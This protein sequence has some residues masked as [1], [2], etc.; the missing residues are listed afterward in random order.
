MKKRLFLIIAISVILCCLFAFSVSAKCSKCTDGWTLI[1]GEDGYFGQIEALNL[2]PVCGTQ[3]AKKVFSPMFET[4]GYSHSDDGIMQ[5]YAVNRDTVAKFEELTG[6]TIKFGSVVATRNHVGLNPLDE[7]GNPI[8]QKVLS[9]DF[10]DTKY[11]IF[12]V[13]VRGIPDIAKDTT[14][15]ICS[16]YV[17]LEDE[18]GVKEISYLNNYGTKVNAVAVTY[19]K[20]VSDLE[21]KVTDKTD[22]E[23]SHLVNGVKFRELTPTELGLN[24]G[25][26]W[27]SGDGSNFRQVTGSTDYAYSH[28]LDENSIPVGSIIRVADGWKFRPEGWHDYLN[29]GSRPGEIKAASI[30]VTDEWWNG[31]Y[32]VRAFN[33]SKTSAS[34][35]SSTTVS[36]IANKFE[37]LVP[38]TADIPESPLPLIPKRQSWNTD[39]SLKILTIGNSFSDDSM[40]YVY[41]IAK[42]T[43]VKNI[44]LGNLRIDGCSLATHL[45]NARNDKAAYTYRHWGNGET[46]WTNTYNVKISDTVLGTD[47]DYVVLQQVSG[48]SN[49]AS[50]YDDVKEMAGIIFKLDMTT[51]IAWNMTWSY[52]NDTSASM[53]DGI[54]DAVEAK[55]MTGT[56]VSL[57]IP[58]GT[59]I[60]NARTSVITDN[61]TSTSCV[62]MRDN[63]HL[64][65]DLGRYIAALT[66]VRKLTGSGISNVKAP[67]S[68]TE[69]HTFTISD[70]ANKVAIESAMNAVSYP[71]VVTNSS[72]SETVSLEGLEELDYL[73]LNEYSYF[74][75]SFTA[76]PYEAITYQKLYQVGKTSY[77]NTMD[78][79]DY[80][81]T[82]L[83]TR[84]TLPV[85]SVI[86]IDTDNGW[87]Y[88]AEGWISAGVSNANANA[89]A[90]KYVIVTEEWWGDY[91][92]R[93]FNISKLNKSS[94]G[95]ASYD[96]INS[97]FKI[98]V[99]KDAAELNKEGSTAEPKPTNP[100]YEENFFGPGNNAPEG[101]VSESLV[102][103]EITYMDTDGDGVSEAY[104]ALTLEAYGLQYGY[105][106][107]AAGPWRSTT[108]SGF[109]ATR[110]FT[111]DL[112]VN[113]AVIVTNNVTY[114]PEGYIDLHKTNTRNEKI[115]LQTIIITDAF[116]TSRYSN[117]NG[118]TV[119]LANGAEYEARG[120]NIGVG[121][122]ETPLD[123]YNKFKIYIPVDKIAPAE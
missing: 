101:M 1:M 41:Y 69:G 50:T 18:N 37:V 87:T 64:S 74:N 63:K 75:S 2:C 116:W 117:G 73:G 68:D 17:I 61:S 112:L 82:K 92:V 39:N 90:R 107:T 118:S 85:G 26:Y 40:E 53:Y 100:A 34:N 96:T 70:L 3:N 5:H 119:A 35:I 45:D 108:I 6:K 84:E 94:L 83:F 15:I 54:V 10:T 48:S 24:V 31:L 32:N 58:T 13:V 81:S 59:A 86:Y 60:Q 25:G 97:V 49:V 79:A 78:P 123:V 21:N 11:S 120:F 47:W 9:Y 106:D 36:E 103:D 114:R 121:S 80:Y 20:V 42:A 56:E 14:E 113:G 111:K 8:N 19:N 62:L 30:K 57:V 122:K 104:R 72:V 66:F 77:A 16:V 109:Y 99:P 91:T 65:Y 102:V 38:I 33:I 28:M 93:A 67:T 51:K 23:L 55:V 88:D 98:Y 71:Y 27:N 46:G 76:L 4:L 115:S 95:S 52:R 44:E 22:L 110:L 89:R 7:N 105:Y 29:T 12:D 43:G